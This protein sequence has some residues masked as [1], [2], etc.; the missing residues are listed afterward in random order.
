MAV[1][2]NLAKGASVQLRGDNRFTV[3]MFGAGWDERKSPGPA[4]DA[5]PIVIG[6]DVNGVTKDDGSW[7]CFYNQPDISWCRHSGDNTSGA[8]ELDAT[9]D[10]ERMWIDLAQ[11]PKEVY[12]IDLVINIFEAKQKHQSFGDMSKGAIRLVN[13]PAMG[14]SNGDEK[15]HIDL[16]GDAYFDATGFL[17]ITI[18]RSGPAWEVQ[19]MDLMDARWADTDSAANATNKAVP[20]PVK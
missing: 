13:V 9:G 17:A 8:G 2:L 1:A 6:R 5:D 15:I 14:D 4:I 16:S 12:S 7:I 10:D 3:L 11:V 20:N 19:R 18:V